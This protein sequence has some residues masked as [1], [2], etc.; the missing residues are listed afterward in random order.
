MMVEKEILMAPDQCMWLH[1]RPEP[2][3]K[4]S[5]SLCSKA[6]PPPAGFYAAPLEVD[7]EVR[8]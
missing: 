8:W 1:R 7:G 4:A 5:A 3:R 2:A 6:N